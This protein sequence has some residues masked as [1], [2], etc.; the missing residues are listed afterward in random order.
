MQISILDLYSYI[1]EIG[2]Y[3]GNKFV[4]KYCL[5]PEEMCF[6]RYVTKA[7]FSVYMWLVPPT[8]P[9]RFL[10]KTNEVNIWTVM[11]DARH[12]QFSLTYY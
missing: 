12:E 1:R 9:H 6:L 5:F 11:I 10:A 7:F 2:K 3:K 8:P 4:F